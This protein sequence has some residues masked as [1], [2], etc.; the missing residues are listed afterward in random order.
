L[1]SSGSGS[2]TPSSAE[3]CGPVSHEMGTITYLPGV[4]QPHF[5]SGALAVLSCPPGQTVA[6]G[7]SQAT[8]Q[9]GKWTATLGFCKQTN[10]KLF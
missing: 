4:E 8:C 5:P 6:G 1:S 2:S 10:I 9:N 3:K 7:A